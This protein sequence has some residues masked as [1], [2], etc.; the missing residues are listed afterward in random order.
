MPLVV[1]SR[2]FRAKELQKIWSESK[3]TDETWDRTVIRNTFS[4]TNRGLTVVIYETDGKIEWG[5]LPSFHGLSHALS[6]LGASDAWGLEQESNALKTLAELVQH[7]QFKQYLLT[8][9]FLETSRRSGLTYMFRK[10]RP[11]V[12][13]DARTGRSKYNVGDLESQQRTKDDSTILCTLCMHP[14]AYY[15]GSWAG[16]MCPTDDVIAALMLMRADEQMLWRRSNQ[17]SPAS[18]QSG[19]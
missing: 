3:K 2:Y 7:R 17:H 10:L 1:E 14:I 15:E 5:W 9:S 18:P 8:G 6:T 19:L 11:T 16:A 13:L 12:V 4:V